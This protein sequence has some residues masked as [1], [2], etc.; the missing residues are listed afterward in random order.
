MNLNEAWFEQ[1]NARLR[2][3]WASALKS[4]GIATTVT[5][6]EFSQLHRYAGPF[7]AARGYVEPV[8]ADAYAVGRLVEDLVSF[9]ATLAREGVTRVAV[10]DGYPQCLAGTMCGCAV[11]RAEPKKLIWMI[12][13]IVGADVAN[14]HEAGRMIGAAAR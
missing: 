1:A 3:A 11:C 13:G 6:G 8:I 14:H 5:A 7:D 9:A 10:A 12:R 4:N 2:G